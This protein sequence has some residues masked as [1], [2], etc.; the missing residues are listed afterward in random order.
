MQAQ[1]ILPSGIFPGPSKNAT[2]KE[3]FPRSEFTSSDKEDD[4]QKQMAQPAT[5]LLH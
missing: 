2:E 1:K 5:H 3:D 4:L